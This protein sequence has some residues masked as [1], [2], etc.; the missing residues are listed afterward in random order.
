MDSIL[1][2]LDCKIKKEYIL[3]HEEEIESI[4]TIPRKSLGEREENSK[5]IIQSILKIFSE[6]AQYLL[7]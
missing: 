6:I 5:N 7:K 1:V 4:G 3:I 2:T